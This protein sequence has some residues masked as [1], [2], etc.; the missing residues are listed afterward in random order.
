MTNIEDWERVVYGQ[1]EK[2]VDR[3][4][5]QR[6]YSLRLSA[7]PNVPTVPKRISSVSGRKVPK[8]GAKDDHRED[9][10]SSSS[11]NETTGRR[12]SQPSKPSSKVRRV[13]SRQKSVRLGNSRD[14]QWKQRKE[15]G[16]RKFPSISD[17]STG[18]RFYTSD[19]DSGAGSYH[20]VPPERMEQVSLEEF[21]TH[22]GDDREVELASS[23]SSDTV[24]EL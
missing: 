10:E 11:S 4:N 21:L 2:K 20:D 16:Q 12:S 23:T 8:K 6:S 22:G 15:Y 13:V 14:S 17:Q 24:V 3:Q 7:E 19:E 5:K 1:Y 18:W 9:N